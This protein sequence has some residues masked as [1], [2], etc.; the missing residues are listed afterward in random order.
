MLTV[1]GDSLQVRSPKNCMGSQVLSWGYQ[2][3][4][5]NAVGR[6]RLVFA[7]LS[8]TKN[9]QGFTVQTIPKIGMQR[10][11]GVKRPEFSSERISRRIASG[12]TSLSV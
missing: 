7:S 12:P 2:G 10:V 3:F 4:R 8:G 1:Q 6:P 11:S 9:S 5:L